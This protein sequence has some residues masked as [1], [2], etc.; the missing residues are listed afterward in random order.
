MQNES[1]SLRIR[2]FCGQRAVELSV[3]AI[4]VYHEIE[5]PHVHTLERLMLLVPDDTPERVR[6]AAAL[7][8]YAVEEMYPDTFSDLTNDHANEAVQLARTVIEWAH[9]II[10]KVS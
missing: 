2:C 4:L 10:T 1:L 3:K 9:E 5:Y 7:T 6:E 8:T